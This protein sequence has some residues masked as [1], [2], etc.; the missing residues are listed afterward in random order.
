MAR[1]IVVAFVHGIYSDDA[2]YS[3]PMQQRLNRALPAH[4]RPHVK[5]APVFWGDIV[6]PHT[7]N[8][9]HQ[10]SAQ[11]RMRPSLARRFIVE[12]LGDAAAYQKTRNRNNSAYYL[13]QEKITD[14]LKRVDAL[15]DPSRPLVFIAHSLGC[16]IVSSYAWDFARMRPM[17]DEELSQWDDREVTSFVRAMRRWSPMRRLETFAGLVTMGSNMPLFTFSFGPENVFPITRSKDEGRKPAFPGAALPSHVAAQARWLNFYSRKDLLS[18]PLKPLNNAYRDE[19]RIEDIVVRT[20]PLWARV[21]LPGALGA[22]RAHSGYWTN[23]V[24]I[25][26]TADLLASLVEADDG[27][28]GTSTTTGPWT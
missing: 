21:F 19:P 17:T 28:G 10:L 9:L 22:P 11:A 23:A 26:R 15:D 24:V 16:H 3:T 1:D 6:R 2:S 14:A 20:D 5:Y 13:V 7:R 25:R 4:L 18:Y 27:L 12:G 8:F